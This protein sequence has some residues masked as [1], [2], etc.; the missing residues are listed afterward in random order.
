MY[1]LNLN[2]KF[3]GSVHDTYIWKNSIIRREM[4]KWHEQN[5]NSYFWLLGDSGYPLE[6]W[7]MTPLQEEHSTSEQNYNKHHGRTRSII[8]Q[9]N[10][11]LKNRW[12]C[13][14]KHRVLHYHP[15]IA[16]NIIASCVI[17]HNMCI[18]HKLHLDEEE[19]EHIEDMT[20]QLSL[21]LNT[22]FYLKLDV[23]RSN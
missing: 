14:L 23:C 19:F 12:R 5:Q 22:K 13:L 9:C 17:L 8:E 7:L 6:P 18:K 21:R 11:V 2:A 4:E 20:Y 10:G 3:P 1:I 15:E 16:S